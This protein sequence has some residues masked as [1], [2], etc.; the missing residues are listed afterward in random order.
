MFPIAAQQLEAWHARRLHSTVR[1]TS[2]AAATAWLSDAE[3]SLSR[4]TSSV[5]M[6][7]CST[8]QPSKLQ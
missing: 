1:S 5:Q 6:L 4:R 3:C 2:A 8:T 7:P